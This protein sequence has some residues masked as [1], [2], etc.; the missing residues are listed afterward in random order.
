MRFVL[1]AALLLEI[2][3]LPAVAALFEGRAGSEPVI[4]PVV[5]TGSVLPAALQTLPLNTSIEPNVSIPEIDSIQMLP[6]VPDTVLGAAQ[7]QVPLVT[8]PQPEQTAPQALPGLETVGAKLEIPSGG[9]ANGS[10]DAAQDDNELRHAFDKSADEGGAPGPAEAVETVSDQAQS[11][12]LPPSNS[13][14]KPEAAEALPPA[15]SSPA[16]ETPGWYNI[17]PNLV[18][19]SNLASGV[20]AAFLGSQG[21]IVPTAVAII[22]ANVF[23]MLDGRTARALKVKNPMGID[24][25]SLADVVSFGAAPALLIFKA[26][27][28]PALGW[29]GFP[30]AAAFAFGGM[31]RLARFNVGAHAEEAGTIPHKKNDSFTG[32]PIPGGAGVIAATALALAALPAAYVAPFAIV[33]TLLATG[34]MVSRLPYPA[35]KKGGIKALIVP[36]AVGLAAVIP[37]AL[38]GL[39]S[40]IPAAVFGLYLLSGPLIWLLELLTA[41]R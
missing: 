7:I 18:T 24:L 33:A 17:F 23:D 15:A 27:L 1:I 32:L 29:W 35:F 14:R 41:R 37:L 10:H 20:L 39:Y 13:E 26:A 4:R 21:R 5:I 30:I 2:S 9:A 3:P 6:R 16:R 28:L 8:E 36:A 12:A 25:D 19:G 31:Y 11:A 38:L 34:A 22:A 40:F